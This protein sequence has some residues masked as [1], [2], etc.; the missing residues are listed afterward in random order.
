MCYNCCHDNAV[1]G[2]LTLWDNIYNCVFITLDFPV[3]LDGQFT[4]AFYSRRVVEEK[5][6]CERDALGRQDVL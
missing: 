1:K 4:S 2:F 5:V 6:G 3:I